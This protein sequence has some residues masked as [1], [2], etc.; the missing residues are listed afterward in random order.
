MANGYKFP[1]TGIRKSFVRR[2]Q[3]HLGI[4]HLPYSA[5]DKTYT[6][7][8][9]G[10]RSTR[11][12]SY[13][14]TGVTYRNTPMNLRTGEGMTE[15]GSIGVMN[16]AHARS[17]SKALRSYGKGFKKAVKGQVKSEKIID[18]GAKRLGKIDKR[19]GGKRDKKMMNYYSALFSS[20]F[21]PGSVKPGRLNRLKKQYERSVTKYDKKMENVSQRIGGRAAKVKTRGFLKAGKG[22]S[23]FVSETG[24]SPVD[25]RGRATFTNPIYASYKEF[26]K[27]S[28]KVG[29]LKTKGGQGSGVPTKYMDNLTKARNISLD[30]KRKFAHTYNAYNIRSMK[31]AY[32]SPMYRYN[33]NK[34]IERDNKELMK[35]VDF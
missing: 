19:L 12:P 27:S 6:P 11:R 33:L 9:G 10:T 30:K 18:K 35:D 14:N 25:A 16:A 34:R 1:N 13:Y 5:D 15:R 29:E 4:G 8:T 21:S 32:N 24:T 26:D 2:N 22:F 23:G 31:K 20:A 17:F 3:A 7:N 28:K